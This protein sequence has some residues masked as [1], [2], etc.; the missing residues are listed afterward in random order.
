[1]STEDAVAEG[2]VDTINNLR[3]KIL[4]TLSVYPFLSSSMVHVGIGT[5]TPTSLWKPILEA[6]IQ[7]GRI[8][9]LQIQRKSPLSRAQSYTIYHLPDNEYPIASEA[10]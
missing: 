1:M 6:L 7:E 3:A 10:F 9:E 5:S 4:H 2:A 8:C